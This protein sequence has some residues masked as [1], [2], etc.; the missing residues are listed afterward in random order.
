MP[1]HP[2]AFDPMIDPGYSGATRVVFVVGDPIGQVKSPA[3]VTAA[4]RRRGVDAI[5]VPAHVRPADLTDFLSVAWRMPNVDGV[6]VTVP[7]KVAA[8]RAC[9]ALTPRA[10]VIGAVNV[11]RRSAQGWLGDM[12]DGDAFVDAVREAGAAVTG[13]R[14]LLVGVG[15]A[16]VAIAHA[17]VAA[18]VSQLD[19][20][21]IDVK[22]RDQVLAQL[23]QAPTHNHTT[24]ATRL[25]AGY[26]QGISYD[27]VC[28]ASPLGMRQG[29]PLPVRV[30]VLA[31][32]VCVGDVVTVPAEPPLIAEARR[33]GCRVSTGE[34]MFRHV[35][36]RLVDFLLETSNA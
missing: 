27:L 23:Q 35:S 30:E 10:R 7:H 18:G 1:T 9:T 12:C 36:T 22:R 6:L 8:V 34:D 28:N 19:L 20:H 33:R 17:L 14:A 25:C 4:L 11:L 32:Q 21:D 15:G 2:R 26:T 29:D 13:Q 3:A 5:C 31:P 16:G 24:E